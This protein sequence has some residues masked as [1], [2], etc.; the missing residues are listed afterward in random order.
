VPVSVEAH[1][2][3]TPAKKSPRSLALPAA[4]SCLVVWEA[5]TTVYVAQKL[6][7]ELDENLCGWRGAI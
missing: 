5:A 4:E 2:T 6:P 7:R 1:V 3:N